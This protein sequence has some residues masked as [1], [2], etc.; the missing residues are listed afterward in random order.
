MAT[1]ILASLADDDVWKRRFAEKRDVIRR[2]AREAPEEDERGDTRNAGVISVP[3]LPLF[4]LIRLIPLIPLIH[5][6]PLR[7]YRATHFARPAFPAVS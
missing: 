3:L 6:I 5:L 2:M 4:P 1:R 7:D